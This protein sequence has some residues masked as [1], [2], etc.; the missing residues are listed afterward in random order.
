MYLEGFMAKKNKY[1]A[2]AKVPLLTVILVSLFFVGLILTI[3]LSIKSAKAKFNDK[4]ELEK[5]NVYALINEKEMKKKIEKGEN[6]IVFLN[7]KNNEKDIK[8]LL[9]KLNDAYNGKDPYDNH[10]NLKNNFKQIY[11][12][13]VESLDGLK[14]FFADNKKEIKKTT[15]APFLWAFK[16]KKCIS[17]FDEAKRK[18]EA[19]SDDAATVRSLKDFFNEINEKSSK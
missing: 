18:A 13:E 17:E 1:N 2:K 11:F 8:D 15:D 7:T 16:D 19:S 5:N 3:V 12:V 10:D 6:L 4:Y 9:K 14:T